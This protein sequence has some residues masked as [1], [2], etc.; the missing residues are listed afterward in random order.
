MMWVMLTRSGVLYTATDLIK[1]DMTAHYG[2]HAG[3]Y[4]MVALMPWPHMAARSGEWL[5]PRF[6]SW[7]LARG[8][9]TKCYLGVRP[10]LCQTPLAAQRQNLHEIGCPFSQRAMGHAR[11]TSHFIQSTNSF[12]KKCDGDKEVQCTGRQVRSLRLRNRLIWG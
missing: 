1:R 3:R 7:Q 2:R 10:L 5:S 11:H 9:K 6:I 8:L 4:V 12:I